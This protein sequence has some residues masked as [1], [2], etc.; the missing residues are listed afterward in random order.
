MSEQVLSPRG[1]LEPQTYKCQVCSGFHTKFTDCGLPSEIV[2]KIEYKDW[3]VLV[4][5]DQSYLQVV[6]KAW[7]LDERAIKPQYGPEVAVI[8]AHDAL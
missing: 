3:S 6:F 1:K 7:D 2:K 4:A 5:P 8:R